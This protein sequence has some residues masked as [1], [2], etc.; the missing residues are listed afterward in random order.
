M[1]SV[2]VEDRY[3]RGSGPEICGESEQDGCC[4]P[5]PGP[6]D[7]GIGDPGGEP[8][9]YPGD[10][11]GQPGSGD[12]M[13]GPGPGDYGDP[14][15]GSGGYGDPSGGY[16]GTPQPPRPRS[17]PNW[18]TVKSALKK[19]LDR[20]SG[21]QPAIIT[22]VEDANS[23]FGNITELMEAISPLLPAET[24]N[25]LESQQESVSALM[26]L[27][28]RRVGFSLSEMTEEKLVCKIALD[29]NS[30][31]VAKLAVAQLEKIGI[32]KQ[33]QTN[34]GGD[35]YGGFPGYPGGEPGDGGFGDGCEPM[36]GEGGEGTFPPG[37]GGIPPGSYNPPPGSGGMP[38]GSGGIPPG[39]YNPPPGS[40]GPPGSFPPGGPGDPMGGYGDPSGGYGIPGQGTGSNTNKHL[41]VSSFGK[42]L[43]INVDQPLEDKAYRRILDGA[44]TVMVWLRG[45]AEMLSKADRI[46]ILASALK[47]YVD[48][49][50]RFPK[51]VADRPGVV[52]QLGEWLPDERISWMA[53]LLPY[54]GEGYNLPVDKSSSWNEGKNQFAAQVVIPYFLVQDE[55]PAPFR[56]NYPGQSGFYA[57][58]HFVGIAGIGWDAPEWT[59][60]DNAKLL[61]V[62]GYDRQTRPEDIKDGPANTIALLQVP[63]DHKTPWLAGGGST[64]RG[65]SPEDDA[66]LPFISTEYGEEK[67]EKGAFAIMADGKVRFLPASIKPDTFRALVTINGG[68]KID[69]L[70]EIAPVIEGPV[71]T[72]PEPQPAPVPPDQGGTTTP[73][74]VPP[75]TLP[76]TTPPGTSPPIV[77]PDRGGTTS[78]PFVPPAKGGKTSPPLVP[79]VKGTRPSIQPVPQVSPKRN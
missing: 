74:I 41:S 70:D 25:Q 69:K 44:K 27:G 79:P 20:V 55:S 6:G 30:D 59:N 31:T 37:S 47:Q 71:S 40:G 8:G 53:E 3:P 18:L 13:G 36:P 43:V 75:T 17:V 10:P 34:P 21:P 78:P 35:P 29:T 56:V 73:P 46:H 58:T 5:E 32:R 14:M 33:V 54:L 72:E 38:P 64:V 19:V 65:I 9:A 52:D 48:K 12:P 68:E 23:A 51:G 26:S 24:R 76:G 2:R 16:G 45:D 50:G 66:F 57:S 15:G 67:K 4:P 42:I 7:V 39:S 49:E 28:V 62:F 11:M 63:G 22:A 77:P 61:G 60:G 1:A